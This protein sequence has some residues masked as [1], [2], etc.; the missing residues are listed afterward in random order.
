MVVSDPTLRK[1]AYKVDT[2]FD[3]E[4]AVSGTL[5]LKYDFNKPGK[6]QPETITFTGG[7]VFSLYGEDVYGTSTYGGNPD[8]SFESRVVGSFFTASLQYEF[9][10][11]PPF[12]LDT[13]ILEYATEDRK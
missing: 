12:I 10:G 6:I 8:T 11:G 2:Y 5:T 13:V 9:D 7:G 1:T 3:P 4:G